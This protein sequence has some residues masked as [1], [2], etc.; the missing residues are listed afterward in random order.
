MDQLNRAEERYQ[1][2][3]IFYLTIVIKVRSKSI[4]NSLIAKGI[5][6]RGQNHPVELFLEIKA[7]TIC[8][9]CS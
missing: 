4:I 9:K 5:K 8:F 3:K 6:F 2:K 1:N 7:D